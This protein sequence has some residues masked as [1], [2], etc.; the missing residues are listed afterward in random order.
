MEKER[1][2]KRN[3]SGKERREEERWGRL[4]MIERELTLN[5]FS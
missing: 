2:G 5:G 1:F 4:R 3:G